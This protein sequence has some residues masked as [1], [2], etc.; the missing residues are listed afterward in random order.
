MPIGNVLLVVVG[1]WAG[2]SV[3]MT[4][5]FII[6]SRINNMGIVDAAWALGVGMLGILYALLFDGAVMARM[7]VAVFAGAW[8][9]RLGFHILADR[10]IGRPEDGRYRALIESWGSEARRRLFRF[11]QLQ[12]LFV[13]VFSLPFIPAALA[14]TNP[15]TWQFLAAAAIWCVA[16]L[17]ESVADRQL[18]RWR[19]NPDNHGRTCRSG[20]WQYSRH[21][22]YFCE[23]LHW[24]TYVALGI[25]A[26]HGWL[27]LIGPVLMLFF[28]YRVTGI[29]YTEKQAVASRG[30]DYRQYQQTVSAFF[31]WFPKQGINETTSTK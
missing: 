13:V 19:N 12:A 29:P 11:F 28:L 27:T 30:D 18:A 31:P 21:P 10:V 20:L 14:P 17:G 6:G 2:M 25:A 22:N 8:G 3:L 4:V 23:W 24:W 9:L 7:A 26:P 15:Q 16:V 5:M 1:A